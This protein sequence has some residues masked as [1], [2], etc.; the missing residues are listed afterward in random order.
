MVIFFFVGELPHI[1]EKR[2]VSI[3]LLQE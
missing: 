2:V 3:K 1:S